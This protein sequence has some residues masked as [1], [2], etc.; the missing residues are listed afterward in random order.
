MET[1]AAHF[2]YSNRFNTLTSEL[3]L[4]NS[5]FWHNKTLD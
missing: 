4:V 3:I 2:F 5:L 1:K